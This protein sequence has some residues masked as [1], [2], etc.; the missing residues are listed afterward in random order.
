MNVGRIAFGSITTESHPLRQGPGNL[1]LVL[2]D[3]L[4]ELYRA[5]RRYEY[6]RRL[7]VPAFA[8]IFKR[9][10]KGE[11]FDDVIDQCIADQ[12]PGGQS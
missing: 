6:V 9:C 12:T 4:T 7:S 8:R 11:R 10:L 5:E 2:P 1:C 3:R